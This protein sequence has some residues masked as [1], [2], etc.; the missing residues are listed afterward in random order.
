MYNRST[1]AERIRFEQFKTIALLGRGTFAKVYLVYL[2]D[3]SHEEQQLYALKSMRKDF[4][5]QSNSLESVEL[6]KMILLQVNNPFIV[7]MQ[8]VF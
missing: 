6:E 8:Y 4:I 2:Q 1:T 3:S 5:L 7:K